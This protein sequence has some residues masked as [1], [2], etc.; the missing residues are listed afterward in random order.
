[1]TLGGMA[2]LGGTWHSL[3]S[4]SAT[5]LGVAVA[6]HVGKL[7]AEARAWH[8][9]VS[10]AHVPQQVRFRTTCGA[11]VGSIGA[12]AVLPARVGEALRVGVVRRHVPGSSVVTIAATIV[13]ETG[14]EGAFGVAV[15]AAVMFGG[16]SF[17]AS[18]PLSAPVPG[19][20]AHPAV[21]AVLA[22]FA[23]T[24]VALGFVFRER[25]RPLVSRMA[26]GFSIVRSPRRFAAGVLSWKLV[27]WTLRLGAVYA[28]LVA[29]HVPAAPWTAL[30][31][32]AAQ[33]VAGSVPLLPGNAGTQQAAIGIALAGSASASSLLG[34]GVGM[35]AATAAAD[36]VIGVSALALVANRHDV[37]AALATLRL[38]RRAPHTPLSSM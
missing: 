15:I 2:I 11:F 28:F 6:L 14:I 17:T 34:F 16:R 10:H 12:N 3:A 8:S 1:M 25:A 23:V 33:N 36:L 22:C 7:F 35:Q 9:I 31:V 13:L 21:P 20:V 29:F 24:S 30:V 27:A 26:A 19:L 4:V 5:A 18:G 38:R 32:V 37:R